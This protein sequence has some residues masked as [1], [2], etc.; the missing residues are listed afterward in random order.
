MPAT[1]P[2]SNGWGLRPIPACTVKFKMFQDS[3]PWDAEPGSRPCNELLKHVVGNSILIELPVRPGRLVRSK[4]RL[5]ESGTDLNTILRCFRSF[6]KVVTSQNVIVFK[7][8]F[9]RPKNGFP[10]HGRAR[11]PR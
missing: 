5:T 4:N 3:V 10:S 7:I 9:P 8:S 1:S 11:R 6:K 2:T